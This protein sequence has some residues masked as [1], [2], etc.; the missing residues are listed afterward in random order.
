V[1]ALSAGSPLE[2]P[3]HAVGRRTIVLVDESRDRRSL[4]VDLWYPAEPS[5]AA[6]STY[7]VLPGVEYAAATAQH[8]APAL[9]GRYPLILFSHGRMGTRIMYS[10]VCEALAA[11]G[12]VVVSADH[13]GDA[14]LDWFSGQQA[15]N[16]TNETN[17]VADAHFVLAAL[18]R[19]TEGV[20]INIANAIDHQRVVLAGHS[21]GA[22]TAL[23]T[24]AGGR[25][26]APHPMVK[27]VIGFQAYTA[28]MSDALL[29]RIHMP[30]LL[31]VSTADLTTPPGANADRPWALL[32]GS[33]NWR[34]DLDGAGHQAI[35]DVAL[36]AELAEQLP[37]LPT[38]VRDFLD[39]AAEGSAGAGPQ[40]WRALQQLQ[41]ATTWAF[42]QIVLG[43]DPSA[44]DATAA[45][46]E[47][48]PGLR[49]RRR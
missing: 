31:V 12:A 43:L 19:A 15:D 11:R 34:L 23:A 33:P 38:L 32:P 46:L 9:A 22:F 3:R 18:L 5:D 24:A 17:R 41:V 8:E 39:S 10:M 49:L 6:R 13:P 25:G 45:E 2:Q 37:E 7:E 21:Y 36:Y 30:A 44:G 27:A 48:A 47:Q 4:G 1:T 26:V 42:L 16:R 20:P 14:L 28:M 40:G 35:S 29:G